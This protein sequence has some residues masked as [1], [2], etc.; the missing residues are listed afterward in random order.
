MKLYYYRGRGPRQNFGDFLNVWMWPQLLPDFFDDDDRTLFLGIGSILYDFLPAASNKVVFGAGYGGYTTLPVVD[1][2]WR[3]YFV[4]G[5]W[6]ATKLGLDPSLAIGDAAILVR[7]CAVP[8]PPK[9][10]KVSFIPHWESARDGEWRDVSRMAGIHYIDPCDEIGTVMNDIVASDLLITEAMHGAIFADAVR[11]PWVP[12]RPVR[13]PHRSKWL[14]WASALNLNLEF[15][16]IAP[17]NAFELGFAFVR[18]NQTAARWLR[19]RGTTL[20]GISSNAFKERAARSLTVAVSG[21]VHLS[22]DAAIESAHTRM[23]EKLDRLRRD[24]ASPT[25]ARPR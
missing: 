22:S 3:F 11:V 24:Y 18:S 10:H 20:R 7:S 2:R 8:N 5:R 17:S 13:A 6:T 15:T 25:G 9:T 19:A 14:D 4:R 12:I 16:S 23:L 1:D 21:P